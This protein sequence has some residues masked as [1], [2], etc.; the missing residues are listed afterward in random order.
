MEAKPRIGVLPVVSRIIVV[1]VLLLVAVGVF[2]DDGGADGYPGTNDGRRTEDSWFN[3]CVT[4]G[5][6]SSHADALKYG[7][8]VINSTTDL[9]GG[10]SSCGSN[11]DLHL[12]SGFLP[13]TVRGRLTCWNP[14][15]STICNSASMVLDFPQLDV[16]SNDWYDRRKTAV[17]EAGH[18][19][20]LGHS[21]SGSADA[22]VQGAVAGTATVHRRLSSHHIYGH[23]NPTY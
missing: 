13:G 19:A 1:S 16:G 20:G 14:T 4:S 17:H 10:L 15:S 21:P 5:T 18:G 8:V 11:T 6:S 9:N 22:M 12:I 3:Y 23:I 7:P 2:P